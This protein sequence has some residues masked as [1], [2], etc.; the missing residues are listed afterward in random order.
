MRAGLRYGRWAVTIA[1]VIL[2]VAIVTS[3]T[4][5]LGPVLRRRA[6]TA[7]SNYI[8]RPLHIG[9]LGIHLA[10]GRFVVEDLVIEGL[11]P[12]SRPFLIARRIT[13]ALSWTALLHREVLIENIDMTEWRMYVEMLRDGRHS[14][15]KFTR[16]DPS[17]PRR[18]VTTLGYVRARRGEFTF[19]D[20]GAP[21]STVAR[22]LEVNVTKTTGYHGQVW[23]SDGTVRISDYVPMRADMRGTFTIDGGKVLFDRLLLYTDG[24]ESRVDGEVNLAT[25][26]DMYWNVHSR[27]HFPTMRRIFFARDRFSLSGEG[28]FDGTFELYK[29]YRVLRGDFTS[30][31]AGLN[32][33]RFEHLEGSLEW[34]PN[35]FVVYDASSGF[36]GGTTRFEYTMSPLGMAGRPGMAT[37]EATYADVDLTT[38]TDFLQ[39]AGIRLA[40]RASGRNVLRWPLGHF[41]EHTGEGRMAVTPPD[42]TRLMTRVIPIDDLDAELARGKPWGPFSP[43]TPLAP[44]P[45]GGEIA[46]AYGPEWIDIAPSRMATPS[47]Y[48]EFQGRT[49]YGERTAMPFHVSSSD[50]QESDRLLAGIMTAFGAPTTAIDI[51]GFGH[52]DGTMSGAFKRPHIEGRFEGERMRAW[53]VVWGKGRADLVVDNKYLTIRNATV[54]H[55]GATVTAEGRFSLGYPREDKGEEIDARIGLARWPLADLRHGFQLDSYLV[56]GLASGDYHIYGAYERPFGFGALT[57][58]KGD[59]YGETFE[60][61]SASMRFEGNGVRMDGIELKKSSGTGTGAAFIGWNGTYSFNFDGRRFPVESVDTFRYPG[62]PLTG[63]LEFRASGSGTFENP[64]YDVRGSVRDLFVA[65]EGI[66]QVSGG[67]TIRG[68]VMTFEM[69][70][71]SPRLAVSGTGRIALTPERDAEM[72]FR[73][74]DTSIDPYARAFDPGLSPFTT[75]VGSGSIRVVGELRNPNHLLVDAQIE[76][77]DMR[78]F[79]Y[80]L[81]NADPIRLVLDQNVIRVARLRLA[82]EGTQLDLGGTVGLGDRR[83]ALQLNGD[84]N[85]GILQGFVRDVRGS[86]RARVSARIDGPLDRPSVSGKAVFEDGRVRHFALPHALEAIGGEMTFDQSG[87]R[88]DGLTARL[89]GGDVRFAGRV[90]LNGFAPGE[91]D[92]EA[93]GRDMRLR[94]PEGMRSLVDADLTLRGRFESPELGGS[95]YVRNA[96]WTRRFDTGSGLIELAGG[97]TPLAAVASSGVPTVPLRYD[98]RI[99]APSTLR[100]ENNTARIVSSADL[101]LRG[102]F[103]HPLLFGHAEID[104]G[105][106]RFEGKRYVVTR[107]GIDFSNPTKIEPFFD[108]EAETSVRAPGQNYRVVLSAAGTFARF[109]YALS[110]DPPLPPVDILSLLLADAGPAGDIELQPYASSRLTRSQELLQARAAR[111]LTGALA[112]GIERTVQQTLGVDTFQLSPSL[113]DP[114]Q[115]STARL[116]PIARLTIGKRIS[117]RVYLTFSRS[118][119]T[120]AR[121]QVILLEYD[122]SDRLSWILSQNED[123]TYALD[124]RVRKVF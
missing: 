103:D 47:T 67:L 17:G 109:N 78:L 106:V 92:I 97:A 56:E 71:G 105:E 87:I 98:V 86:G 26:P 24:A 117:E 65:D 2:A 110:S 59:A 68:T 15:P 43:H 8:R 40:G 63:Q 22:N 89:G 4:V 25:W 44:V 12:Q 20:H 11:T 36:Y 42:G 28:L 50:W 69:E 76:Q 23:F 57:I 73:V 13:V 85:L 113:V 70:A 62:A 55:G 35:S 51:G 108:I 90:G 34:L 72:S 37:F 7:G 104:R 5:D 39:T 27:V 61:A 74:T 79:D 123:R 75:A 3:L 49:A 120:A 46:Y 111:A 99:V 83:I 102:T 18:V 9:R 107:G 116:N 33:Y 29:G 1:A 32:A 6:E 30:A 95:V 115:S 96:V 16:D 54:T 60:V 52:F 88:L 81:R 114:Y 45:V 124:V 77:L 80:R 38:F 119:A 100:V 122:Q 82:G 10:A 101:N 121:D 118:L 21:W 94:Y 41:S 64:R 93:T 112:Q 66:G 84:A 53:D 14:F 91:L 19:E 58:E 31:L 48:A